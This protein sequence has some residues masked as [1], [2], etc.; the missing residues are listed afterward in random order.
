MYFPCGGAF[1]PQAKMH[2]RRG[3]K[4][5]R[6][7]TWPSLVLQQLPKEVAFPQSYGVTSYTAPSPKVPPCCVVP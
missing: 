3:W 7:K 1:V 4:P 2:P 6:F 5:R